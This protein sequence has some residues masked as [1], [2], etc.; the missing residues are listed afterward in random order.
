MQSCAAALVACMAF[1]CTKT[2]SSILRIMPAIGVLV[3]PCHATGSGVTELLEWPD[4]GPLVINE[5]RHRCY[6]LS[7][8]GVHC[9]CTRSIC[10]HFKHIS[11]T[12]E[13]A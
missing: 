6:H 10:R 2:T 13:T 4:V 7:L 3:S 5:V 11:V 1:Q 9:A 8:V 12:G